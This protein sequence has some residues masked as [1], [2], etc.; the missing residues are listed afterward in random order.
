MKIQNSMRLTITVKPCRDSHPKGQLL[1]TP[2][3]ASFRNEVADNINIQMSNVEL[4]SFLINEDNISEVENIIK[5]TL[6]KNSIKEINNR[7][8]VA[9]SKSELLINNHNLI[10]IPQQVETVDDLIEQLKKMPQDTQNI[11]IDKIMESLVM[12]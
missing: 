5:E 3:L 11:L 12:L 1:K 10:D 6:D 2:T 4:L 8:N 9:D 7:K